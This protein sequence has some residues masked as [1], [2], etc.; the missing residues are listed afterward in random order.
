M[1]RISGTTRS[2]VFALSLLVIFS[3]TVRAASDFLSLGLSWSARLESPPLSQP[4]IDGER[5]YLPLR[6]GKLRALE[7]RDGREAWTVD[8][9]F[10][11]PL[12][13]DSGLL[14][15]ATKDE[16]LA[17]DAA[18]GRRRWRVPL[19][20][21][22][23]APA[24]RGGWI[25]VASG[26]D[27]LAFRAADG[28]LVWRLPL[29]SPLRTAATIDGDRVYA[30]L[31]DSTLAAIEITAGKEVWRA[32]LPAPPGSITAAGER[33]YLGCADK[34]FYAL[35]AKDGDRDWRWRASADLLAPVAFDDWRVYYTALDNVV[36]A[37]DAGSGVQKW[38]YAMETR[39]LAGPTL[40]GDLLILSGAA[41]LRAVRIADGTLAGQWHAPAELT[42]APMFVPE[43]DRAGGTRAVIVTGAATG[44]WRVYGL[45]A[46]PEPAPA[47][48]K[49]IPGRPLSP[50][51]P[52]GAPGPPTP[53]DPLL[54]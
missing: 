14:S 53:A 11:T 30:S 47:P 17:I 44:D 32:K 15:G 34:F 19:P 42:D 24:S 21:V 27:L 26:P 41:D 31:A 2:G 16:L 48:L 6:N 37:V 35:D 7:L 52:P 1:L 28:S 8:V 54:P 40:E 51:V 5:V 45:A 46:S 36:R 3:T 49:E 20:D 39:P 43:G 9:A 22:T 13:V 50:D 29:G 25:V 38:R 33:L 12:V 23:F 10:A 4:L 18:T